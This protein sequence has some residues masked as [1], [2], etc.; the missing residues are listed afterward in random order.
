MIK[1]LLAKLKQNREAYRGWKQG[2][3][4]WEEYREIIQVAREQVKAK[5]LTELNLPRDVK[6]KKE[7]FYIYVND[8]RKTAIM[9]ALSGRKLETWLPSMWRKLKCLM[10]FLPQSSTA[11]ALA[12][13]SE[14]Q[15]AK[16]GTG[17]MKNR[18]M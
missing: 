18:P 7:A 11:N 10:T 14:L 4:S 3:V 16:A 13:P 9:W 17:R 8:R 12:T 6:G 1:E 2:Q 5:A 15:K